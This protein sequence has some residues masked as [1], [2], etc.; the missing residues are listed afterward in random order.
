[1]Q[2]DSSGNEFSKLPGS[3]EVA[4]EL[5]GNLGHEGGVEAA[6]AAIADAEQARDIALALRDVSREIAKTATDP[7]Q[8]VAANVFAAGFEYDRI[9]H[10]MTGK[11]AQLVLD[12]S[13][14]ARR[15]Q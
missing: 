2:I 7:R 8:Q 12:V 4:A 5:R 14:F 1:M 3:A 10:N 13:G 15:K 9:R 11:A 6:Q